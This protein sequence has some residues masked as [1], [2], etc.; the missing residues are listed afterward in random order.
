MPGHAFWEVNRFR[1]GEG[2]IGQVAAIG[3]AAWT[4]KLAE[5]VAFVHRS[6][7]EAGFGTLISAPLKARAQVVGVMSLGFQG[8]AACVWKEIGLLEAIGAGVGVAVENPP[9][10]AG[11]VWPCW[12][13]ASASPWICTMASS[14]RS[15]RQR[16]LTPAK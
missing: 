10:S 16:R 4:T 14:S 13:S 8:G 1:V 9:L 3:K 11:D 7:I 5:E 15:C 12:R 2:F 6:V